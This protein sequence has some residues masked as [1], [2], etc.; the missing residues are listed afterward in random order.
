MSDCRDNYDSAREDCI[1]MYD[2]PDDADNLR[3]CIDDAKAD[4]D[5]CLEECR[6]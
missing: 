1:S 2:D 5:D 3:T 6:S 4:Y